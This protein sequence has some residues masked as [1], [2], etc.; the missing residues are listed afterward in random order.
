MD[1]SIKLLSKTSVL[2][3]RGQFWNFFFSARDSCLQ[4]SQDDMKCYTTYSHCSR[5]VYR[6]ILSSPSDLR[7]P[8]RCKRKRKTARLVRHDSSGLIFNHRLCSCTQIAQ[9]TRISIEHRSDRVQ[10]RKACIPRSTTKQTNSWSST[11][12]EHSNVSLE[13]TTVVL[14]K[15][16]WNHG[17]THDILMEEMSTMLQTRQCS[18]IEKLNW[19]RRDLQLLPSVLDLHRDHGDLRSPSQ[20][21]RKTSTC[22]V[23]RPSKTLPKRTS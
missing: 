15:T 22:L 19:W 17:H 3:I 14:Q 5:S 2:S 21:G 1:V 8:G 11:L 23:T 18:T 6:W 13:L 12:T 4:L 16:W 7:H 20:K 9:I 10:G